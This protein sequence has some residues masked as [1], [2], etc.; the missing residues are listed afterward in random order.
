MT[1]PKFSTEN[2]AERLQRLIDLMK[3]QG[4]LT[5]RIDAATVVFRP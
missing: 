3:D 4:R 1:M 5:N 2:S